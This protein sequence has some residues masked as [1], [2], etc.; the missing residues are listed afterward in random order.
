MAH[1]LAVGCMIAIALGM[2]SLASLAIFI[3][4]KRKTNTKK[5][6]RP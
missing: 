6:P 1:Y 5:G 2:I 4:A 3:G